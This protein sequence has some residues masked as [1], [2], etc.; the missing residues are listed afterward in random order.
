MGSSAST[1]YKGTFLILLAGILWGTNGLFARF[2]YGHG[3]GPEEVMIYRGSLALVLC[4][5]WVL[6]FQRSSLRLELRELPFMVIYGL[7][8]YTLFYLF[9]FITVKVTSLALTALL[10]NT[11]PFFVILLARITLRER[12]TRTKLVALALS[13]AGLLLVV[14]VFSEVDVRPTTIGLITG[15]ASGFSNA[16]YNLLGKFGLRRHAPIKLLFYGLGFGLVFAIPIATFAPQGFSLPHGADVWLM[17]VLMALLPA[18]G[19]YLAFITGLKFVDSS[20]ASIVQTVEPVVA[21]IVGFSVFGETLDLPQLLGGGL[22]TIAIWLIARASNTSQ[23]Q[24]PLQ[25]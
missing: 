24:E 13:L 11:S 23:I 22:I 20:N 6:L 8:G 16:L 4:L 1:R 7:C 5:V 15:L 2:L 10:I 17:L 14:G 19:A 21:A 9:F 18:F 3:L 12:V 25:V